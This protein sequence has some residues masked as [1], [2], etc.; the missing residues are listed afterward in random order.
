M[1]RPATQRARQAAAMF[2]V[3]IA[4]GENATIAHA[5]DAARRI[6]ELLR[7]RPGGQ[8]VLL[9]GP[10]GSGKSSALRELTGPARGRTSVHTV[11]TKD[12]AALAARSRPIVDCFRAPLPDALKSLAA[13]GLADASL[14]SLLPGDLSDGQRWRLALAIAAERVERSPRRTPALVAIDEF[15]A[16]LDRPTGA[17]VARGVRRW[18]N[19]LAASE[20]AA[21]AAPNVVVATSHD[22]LAGDLRPDIIVTFSLHAPPRV[23]VVD[24]NAENGPADHVSI[25]E[26]TINDY[27]VLARFHYRAAE[28]ATVVR[29][30]RADDPAAGTCKGALVADP[31][32]VLVVSM[33]TLNGRWREL[34]WPGRYSGP[35]RRENAG[36]LN[37][38]LRCISRVIV[39]PRHRASGVAT[40]LVREYLRH[41]LTPATEAVAAMGVCCPFFRR[42]G[43]IQY[44]LAPS[45]RDARLAD[46]IAAADLGGRAPDEP[47]VTRLLRG[48]SRRGRLVA[49][50]LRRWA[51]ESRA[52]RGLIDEP[53]ERVAAT[54]WAA[55]CAPLVAYAAAEDPPPQHEDPP[56]Q[57]GDPPPQTRRGKCLTAVQPVKRSGGGS[58]T[59]PPTP[60]PRLID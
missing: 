34:A 4:P 14:F 51:G 45:E 57:H 30:L 40:A 36:R 33:P 49:R 35:D 53:I 47:A 6:D 1:I 19:R 5:R 48:P 15:A 55:L 58:A 41:P 18:L 50:E 7:E 32:G 52:S 28:P 24:D 43:M 46:A 10:S 20:C 56:P 29:V 23:V 8:V 42:A 22:D 60:P 59:E 11:D 31:V 21:S 38:E 54:A 27:H 26:G 25:R 44:T 3:T 12:L 16:V 37:R 39:D 13:F 2:G 17:C 9:V